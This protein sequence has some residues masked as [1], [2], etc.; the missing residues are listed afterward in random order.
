VSPSS[1]QQ[2]VDHL[3][4]GFVRA[5][6]RPSGSVAEPRRSTDFVAI[7][8]LVGCLPTDAEAAAELGNREELLLVI[9]Y[10]A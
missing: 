8:P 4:R 9:E 2:F 10:E 1:I 6:M 5:G 7:D 3:G